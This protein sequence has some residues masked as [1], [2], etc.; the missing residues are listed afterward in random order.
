MARLA[1]VCSI[2]YGGV[3][4]GANHNQRAIDTV[5]GL[6]DDAARDK[7]DIVVLP[8]VFNYLGSGAKYTEK[9]ER[10]SG[11]CVT[12]LGKKAKEHHTYVVCPI[13][14]RRGSH[15]Y[16]SAILLD[17]K[18]QL[19]GR[20]HKMFPTIGEIEQ[21]I[22]PGKRSPVFDTDFGKVGFAICFDLNFRP[23]GD[24]LGRQD[25]DLILF[26]SMYRGGPQCGIWA[27]DY[28][29]YFVSATPGELSV[30]VDP[31]GR[32]FARSWNYCRTVT[33]TLNLDYAVCHIDHN[34]L[35]IP[36]VRAK[37]GD[38]FAFEFESPQADF[39]ILG[40]HPR[41]T[42]A[43][44]I[45]EFKLEPRKAYLARA[46]RVRDRTLAKASRRPPRRLA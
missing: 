9:A 6:I 27:H 44:I 37:Y 41:K 17:R 10:A 4:A 7:P 5:C 35:L 15:T 3:P 19:V 46:T 21:G 38:A 18:G 24:D 39:L 14:E 2:S 31:L 16:N 43:D 8:E 42:V 36:K 26:C 13:F 45:R 11:P 30:F 23:V 32:E 34:H 29:C 28:S 40:N 20:Y 22:T 33:R 12:A 25:A 1:R